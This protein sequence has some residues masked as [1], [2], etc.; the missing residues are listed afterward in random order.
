MMESRENDRAEADDLAR[1]QRLAGIDYVKGRFNMRGHGLTGVQQ[2][3]YRIEW[4][5]LQGV[6]VFSFQK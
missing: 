5:R 3:C 2:S 6:K 1:I 4:K